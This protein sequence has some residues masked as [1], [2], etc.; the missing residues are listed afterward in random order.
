MVL[1]SFFDSHHPLYDATSFLGP[2]VVAEAPVG[3]EVAQAVVKE[4]TVAGLDTVDQA[5]T[6]TAVSKGLEAL[7]EAKPKT[8]ERTLP[9]DRRLGTGEM[10]D[11]RGKLSTERFPNGSH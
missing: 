10:E 7:E 11:A 3:P 1:S 8:E 9:G 2:E 5:A 6:A 4:A